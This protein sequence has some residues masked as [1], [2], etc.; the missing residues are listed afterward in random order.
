MSNQYEFLP[1]LR[2]AAIECGIESGGI[3]AEQS[4]LVGSQTRVGFECGVGKPQ[5]AYQTVGGNGRRA[6]PLGKPTQRGLTPH[7]YRPRTGVPMDK[8]Q[9]RYGIRFTLGSDSNVT[10][11]TPENQYLGVESFDVCLLWRITFNGVRKMP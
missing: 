2:D 11:L 10:F 8:S 7:G 1:Q 6:E 5:A 4:K 3:R 9:C